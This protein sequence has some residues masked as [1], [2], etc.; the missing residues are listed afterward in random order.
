M[1]NERFCTELDCGR[2]VA[3]KDE[4]KC[5]KHR[6]LVGQTVTL[7]IPDELDGLELIGQIEDVH[8]ENGVVEVMFESITN[9]VIR[10]DSKENK[11]IQLSSLVAG[12]SSRLFRERTKDGKGWVLNAKLP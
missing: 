8:K 12:F 1:A 7:R 6:V 2:L 9:A 11:P 3:E 4:T 5:S 10:D